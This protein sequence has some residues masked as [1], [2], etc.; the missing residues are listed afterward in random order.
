MFIEQPSDYLRGIY[1]QALWRINPREKAVYLTFDDG[2]IPLVTPWVLSQLKHEGIKATFFMV[3]DNVRKYPDVYQMVVDGGHRIGNHT[4][5]HI[6]GFRHTSR[7]Y[8]ENTDKAN[9]LLNTKLFRPP[10]GWM[11]WEQ[12]LVLRHY[13]RIVMWD[14]VTRDYSK[15][16][17]GPQVLANVMKYTRRGSIITFHDS[18]KSWDNGNLQYALP[19]AIRF[20]KSEGY[21]FKLIPE[22]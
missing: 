16:L 19:A 21:E 5:N 17:R 14:V 6:S 7:F 9:E 2:P 20:L 3:G 8:L 15:K 13:Y 11:R 12:Y 4:F 1:P 10:H 22:K 18:L